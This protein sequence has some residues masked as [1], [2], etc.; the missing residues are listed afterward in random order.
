MHRNIIKALV[1]TTVCLGL[2]DCQ[3][4]EQNVA[5]TAIELQP[6]KMPDY[7]V[8]THWMFTNG[9]K[10]GPITILSKDTDQ[11]TIRSVVGCTYTRKG[12]NLFMPPSTW[13]DC[14]WGSGTAE[15]VEKG[16]SMFP[17][18]VG[19]K[20]SW[21]W[22]GSNSRGW[23]FDGARDCEAIGAERVTI[24]A[25]AFDTFKVVCVDT[26]TGGSRRELILHLSP[27]VGVAVL[28]QTNSGFSGSSRWEYVSGPHPEKSS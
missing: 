17:L 4:T 14:A 1:V 22:N 16:G 9:S 7:S 5:A 3:T 27:D 25:G 18:Q 13:Q 8:G 24:K 12:R 28:F 6:M 15:V 10:T 21:T 23:T 11:T 2:V 19:A 20:Q 26:W